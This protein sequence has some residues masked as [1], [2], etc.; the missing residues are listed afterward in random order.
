MTTYAELPAATTLTVVQV[1]DAVIPA[2]PTARVDIPVTWQCWDDP[3]GNAL[4]G[5]T[6]RVVPAP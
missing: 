6:W 2:R 3:G 1:T 5:D 4:D